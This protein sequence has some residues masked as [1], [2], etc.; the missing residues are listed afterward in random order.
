MQIWPS[1][2]VP[3]FFNPFSELYD[4]KKNIDFM[5]HLSK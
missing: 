1:F 3:I 2:F 5:L 4:K